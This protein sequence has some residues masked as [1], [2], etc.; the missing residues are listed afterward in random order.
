MGPTQHRDICSCDSQT[1]AQSHWRRERGGR[2]TRNDNP[3]TCHNS[4]QFISPSTERKRNARTRLRKKKMNCATRETYFFI[5]EVVVLGAR[6]ESVTC[7]VYE[8]RSDASC[9]CC[10]YE[11]HTF[12]FAFIWLTTRNVERNT[13]HIF[14]V[15][16]GAQDGKSNNIIATLKCKHRSAQ[17]ASARLSCLGDHLFKWRQTDDTGHGILAISAHSV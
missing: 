8:R 1:R 14:Q 6:L 15:V 4:S 10:C 5:A 9:R 7:M 13:E 11:A 17:G 16:Q 3:I 2:E 12:S